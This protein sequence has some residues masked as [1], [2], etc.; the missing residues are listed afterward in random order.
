MSAKIHIGTA[1]WAIPA[2]QRDRLPLEG[3]T[4]E[5]YA[6]ALNA[7]EIN[8]AFHRPHRR[9]TY[10]RWAESTPP[11]FRFAVK[12]ARTITHE[13]RFVDC[14]DLL[15]RAADE[16][17]GLGGKRGP[18]LVQLPPSFAFPGASA[19]T[20]LARVA[21]RFGS[22]A[23]EPRHPSWFER[24]VDALLGQLRI[25]RVAADPA[26]VAA[27]AIP[28]GWDGLV[29]LRLHGSP[30]IYRSDYDAAAIANHAA[31]VAAARGAVWVIYDNTA[32]GHA[33]GNALALKA[34]VTG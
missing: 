17:D 33:L 8:S 21:A 13:R 32:G 22:V 19:E 34:A 12:L 24:E 3:S 16:S 29:Y 20:F 31:R 1:G 27:A 15:D 9:A 5:R 10:E 30:R 6:S 23:I 11:D 26:P 7:V 14:D 25:A 2:P 4:L 28:G 18:L